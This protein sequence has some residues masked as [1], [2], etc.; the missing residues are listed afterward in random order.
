M[1]KVDQVNS[2]DDETSPAS[3]GNAPRKK[4][5]GRRRRKKSNRVKGEKARRGRGASLPYP[6]V[7]FS[8]VLP[9]AEAIQQQARGQPIRRLTL[10]EK[11]DR[12]PESGPS[13]MLIVNSGRYG[14]TKGGYQAEFLELTDLGKIATSPDKQLRDRLSARFKLAIEAVPAFKF[15]YGKNR[16]Q[17]LPSP[18]VMRDSLAE[19]E[20]DEGHRK[21]CVELFLE[22]LKFLGLLRTIAGA[23]RVVP[24]EQALEEAA[25]DA[26]GGTGAPDG[27]TSKPAL[28]VS[29]GTRSAR[30]WKTTCFVIAPIG[31]EGT[32][33]RKHSDMMLVA[34]ITRALEGEKWDVIRADKISRPGMISGQIVEYLIKS[35]LVIADLSFHN[36]NVFYELAI[37]HM[38][39]KPTVHMIRNGDAIPFDLKDFRTISIDTSDKYELVA[40]LETYRAQI[41]TYVRESVSDVTGAPN[42][43]RAFAKDLVVTFGGKEASA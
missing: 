18:E 40:K 2:S 3:A 41:A 43:V 4:K 17:P 10:F 35:A 30:D 21:E 16:G 26:E 27:T 6:P 1:V 7:T 5:A 29:Q 34:L 37:R 8:S 14:L 38:V 31:E 36:P 32:E 13:R 39:G 11:L 23:E 24:I 12:S 22:N 25:G 15:L 20:V 33:E 9:F 28:P 19:G 42:P